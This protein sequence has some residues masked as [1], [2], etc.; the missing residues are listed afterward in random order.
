M[1]TKLFK[2]RNKETG[3]FSKGGTWRYG[4]WTKGGKTWTNIG[5][6]KSHLNQFLIDYRNNHERYPY[7]NA[8]IVEVEVDYDDCF[9]YD[10]NILVEEIEDKQK[11]KEKKAEELY[12]KWEEE[13]ERKLLEE[14]KK[15]YPNG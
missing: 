11:A 4:I 10:V 8:E 1:K 15:K 12:K 6:V 3:E 5:H 13:R 7:H 2:I 9:A 14:L